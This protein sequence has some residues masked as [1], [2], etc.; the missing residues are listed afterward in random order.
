MKISNFQTWMDGGTITFDCVTERGENLKI[1]ITQHAVLE[2]PSRLEGIAKLPGRIYLND[3]LVP[4]Q[5]EKE[6]LLLAGLKAT[7]QGD[8]GLEPM[9]KACLIV[10]LEYIASDAYVKNGMNQTQ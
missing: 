10:H 6:A 3:I 7:V 9:E 2:I 5:S 4:I 1:E 8:A